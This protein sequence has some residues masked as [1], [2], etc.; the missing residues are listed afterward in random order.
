MIS[1]NVFGP[2]ISRPNFVFAMGTTQH[3]MQRFFVD[4]GTNHSPT[5]GPIITQETLEIHGF[6]M[7]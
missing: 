2:G 1:M 4:M 3:D 7:R 6:I 5:L